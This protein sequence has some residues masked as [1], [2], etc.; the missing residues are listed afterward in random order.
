MFSNY[1][2]SIYGASRTVAI[3]FQQNN[4]FTDNTYTGPWSFFGWSQSNLDNPVTYAQWTAAVT[5]SCDQPGELSSGS[6]NS[7][8]GQDTGSSFMP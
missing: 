7:G 1:G 8:F 5:D 3:T 2:T 6:C 4:H